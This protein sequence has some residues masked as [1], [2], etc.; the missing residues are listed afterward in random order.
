M[1]DSTRAMRRT[2]FERDILP[3]FGN[4]LLTEISR[5]ISGRCAQR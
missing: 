4:R 2:I 5:R 3:A 1:A